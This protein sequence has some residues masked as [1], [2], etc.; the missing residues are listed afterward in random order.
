M[1]SFLALLALSAAAA[2]SQTSPLDGTVTDQQNASVSGAAI[3]VVNVENGQT[4]KAASDDRGHWVVAAVPAA[5]YRVSVS[6]KG[7][8][9]TTIEGVK[10]DAGVAATVNAK[11]ELGQITETVDV[12]AGAE[13]VQTT[14]ASVNTTLQGRQIVEL[15]FT[16]RSALELLVTQPGTQTGTTAR[17]SLINGLPDAAINVTTDGINTQ[18][19]FYKSGDGFFTLIPVRPDSV[20]EV[21]MTTSA[22]GA[23]SLGQG[24]AQ[25]K[26][27]TRGGTNA[28]HGGV[29]WQ[30]RNTALDANYYFNNINGQ[31]RDRV[32]LNQGGVHV[33]GPIKKNKLFFFTNYEI[34]RYPATSSTTRTVLAPTA[35]NGDYKYVDSAKALHTVNVLSLAGA[36]GYVSTPDPIIQGTLQTI[37]GLT[38]NGVLQSR[39]ASNNDY[40]RNNLFFQP[41]GLSTST[42][43]TSRIDYNITE[44]HQL[45]VVYTYYVTNS[46]PDITNSVVPIYP[47]TGT[48]LGYNNLVAGQRGNRYAGVVALRSALTS[49]L[50]NEFRSGMNRS[51]TLFRDQVSS[52]SLFSQWRGF[53]PSLGFGLTGVASV[54]GSSRRNSPVKELH[55]DLSYAKGAHLLTFGGSFTQ[56]NFWQ[57]TINNNT[58]PT[59]S[60]GLATNDPINTGSTSIFTAAN[61]PG[62]TSTDL[63]NAGALYA[64][65][66]GRVSAIGRSVALDGTTHQYGNVPTIDQNRQREWGAYVQDTW[67]VAPSLTINLGMRFE[68]QR[69]LEN[70][71]GTYSGVS[72]ASIY[73]ISGIGNLFQPGNLSGVHPT[74]TPLNSTYETPNTWNPSIGLAWQ[75]PGMNGPLGM[76]FGSSKG[77]SVLRAGYSISSLREGTY[78]FY[79]IY[80]SNVGVTASTS[81]D[82]GNFPQYFGAP[83]SVLFRNANLPSR[84]APVSPAY[85]ITPAITDSLNAFDPKL[86]MGYVQ[87]WN[88]ELQR[89]LSKAT[90]LD[91]RYTGN[92][93][94]G[95]W[96]QS[97]LNEVNTFENG[98]QS[99]FYNAQNNLAI[100]NG[101]SI[102]QLLQTPIASLK[103]V[104]FGNAGLPGQKD[105]PIISTALATTTDT[106]TAQQLLRNQVGG[107]ANGI[108]GNVTRMGRLVASGRPA[109]FFVVNPDVVGG[110]TYLVSNLGSSLYDAMQVELRRRMASGLLFQGSYVWSHSIGN[111]AF[112]S[113]NDF[114]SPTTFRDIRLDRNS[115]GSDI[116]HAFKMNWIYELP[117]GPGHALLSSGNRIVKKALEGWEIAGVSRVQSGTP[118]QLTS[119]RTGMNQNET[120]VVLHNMTTAQLQDMMSIR[121]V[122]GSNGVGQVFYL[123]NSLVANTNAA[124]ETNGKSLANLDPN[125]P[126]IGP[127]LSPGQFGYEVFLRNPWQYHLD[128]SLVKITKIKERANVEFRAQALDV[129]NLTNFFVANGPSSASFGQTTSAYRDF[130]GTNDPGA[131][132]LEFVVRVNF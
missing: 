120:G 94:V 71:N 100:A 89:E 60:F 114:S 87:S 81:V 16:S 25:V 129:L 83:G 97:N 36:N 82:P 17:N 78:T 23:D 109:N 75:L 127:Q 28:F 76:I 63:S 1:K 72:L 39:V 106:T 9:T 113:L 6:M 98:F 37:N 34:F 108:S 7:F 58:I 125:A 84:P 38:A 22:A 105:I 4:F 55:D 61:F 96:R 19:N 69:P 53:S 45:Q 49:R 119:G 115:S 15:P 3:Q 18:D 41:Q 107:V 79:N 67:R 123:P 46:T 13:L 91:I 104:N 47:G 42:Y 12:T 70:L 29:F 111:G 90:V 51:V 27:V 131:R 85:P 117:F 66:T 24:A 122:T 80:G 44:K 54:S 56:I 31:P 8:R 26:F 43:D 121:K 35:L 124:F 50:T 52:D 64:L 10:I 118:F 77:K 11:L 86:K 102:P 126:Y 14:D 132:I 5:L 116:R 32:I 48:V 2:Y 99:E 110:G 88:L 128:V 103:T 112:T 40:N 57:Q 59:I 130:S 62:S 20:E 95:E 93:G 73:G 101:I 74:F 68:Q 65:L 33:G 30:H 21:T 92:H